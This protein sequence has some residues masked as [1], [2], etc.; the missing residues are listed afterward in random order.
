MFL[1][2]W[3]EVGSLG[4]AEDVAL[5]HVPA[6][7]IV[8]RITKLHWNL[9]GVGLISHL[10]NHHFLS[11]QAH[12]SVCLCVRTNPCAVLYITDVKLRRNVEAVK[13]VSTEH[14]RIHRCVDC[15]NPP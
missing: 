5:Q 8:E 7:L 9:Q 15:M 3:C 10:K 14:H 13:E 6:H 11:F 12:K 4:D 2:L 1:K